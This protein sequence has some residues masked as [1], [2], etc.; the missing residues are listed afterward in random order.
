MLELIIPEEENW[1]SIKNEFVYTKEQKLQLEHSLVSI[2]KWEQKWKKPFLSDDAM[3]TEETIDYIK[4]M[5]VTKNVDQSVYDALSNEIITQITDYIKDPMTATTISR[6]KKVGIKETI[7]SEIIYYWM[8]ALEIPFECQE[9]HINRLLTLINVC[10]K[11]NT[12][13]KKLSKREIMDRNRTLN[14]ERREKLNSKG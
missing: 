8:I 4:C 6:S 10:N 13:K 9:W 11:K 5:T 14:R 12:P 1:D 7:T 3:T 2:S